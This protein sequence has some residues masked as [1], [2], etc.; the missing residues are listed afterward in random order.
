MSYK[1]SIS[2]VAYS[3]E[4]E[5]ECFKFN[6][7]NRESWIEDL[8]RRSV[9]R[10]G[11]ERK[12]DNLTIDI[13]RGKYRKVYNFIC[14]ETRHWVVFFFNIKTA[15]QCTQ[16]STE[17]SF[18]YIIQ[19][20]SAIALVPYSFYLVISPDDLQWRSTPFLITALSSML[21]FLSIY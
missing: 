13:R 16:Q 9:Q 6:S 10:K 18:I 17:R 14:I 11:K 15:A 7:L 2:F 20:L 12:Y 1:S 8:K 4:E 19:S 3:P 5:E 21:R